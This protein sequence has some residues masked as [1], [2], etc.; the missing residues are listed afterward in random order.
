MTHANLLPYLPEP[1]MGEPADI[2]TLRARVLSRVR[3][4]RPV[5]AVCQG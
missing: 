1:Q 5:P 2:D 4:S 3:A